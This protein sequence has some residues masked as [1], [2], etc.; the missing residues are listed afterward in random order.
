MHALERLFRKRDFRGMFMNPLKGVAVA[1]NLFFVPV[2]QERLRG[3]QHASD[4]CGFDGHTL[5]PV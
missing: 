5:D 4:A 3:E 1:P 2:T